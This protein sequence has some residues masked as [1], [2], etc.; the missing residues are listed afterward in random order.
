MTKLCMAPIIATLILLPCGTAAA[1]QTFLTFDS[2]P[3]DYIGGGI[4]QTWT[5]ADGTFTV[6]STYRGGI[7]A[8]FIAPGYTTWWNLDFG[9]PDA[10]ALTNKEYEGAQ[11]FA[12]HSPTKPGMDVSGSGRGCNRLTGR[13]LVS[14]LAVALDGTIERLAVDFEQHCEG[15]RP[16]LFG[17]LRFNSDVPAVPRVSVADAATLKGNVGTN[18]GTLTVSL[19][20]P[21]TDPVTVQYAT[22]DGTALAGTDYVA[23]TGTLTLD[24]G[25]TA[26]T[27]MIPT[28]GDRLARGDKSFGVRLSSL[29]GTPLGQELANVNI[30]DPNVPLTA[31]AMYGQPGDY[32]G[33]G[34]RLFTVAD[35]IFTP[36]NS[37]PVVSV[38]LNAGDSWSLDFAAPGNV[39]LTPGNYENAQRF[40]F[41]PADAPG[42][43]VS[44]EGRGCN[45]LTG[46][47]DVL[48]ASYSPSGA[49]QSFAAD[50]EQHCEGNVPALFGSLRV[51]SNLQQ[52]SVSNAVIDTINSTAVFTVTMTPPPDALVSVN[53]TT[54]DGTAVA[55]IDYRATSQAVTFGIGEGEQ[56]IT[57]PL[58]T[59]SPLEAKNFFGQLSSPSGA[60]IW[61]RRGSANLVPAE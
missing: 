48:D 30:L 61:I 29:D 10:Q 12:F 36:R 9:P 13:F 20:L 39:P 38:N 35:G 27:I 24:P 53:F 7:T 25:T 41:Q 26:Q 57:V 40:P 46:R 2:Q 22:E 32:I 21:S 11:R 54:V 42:L 23:S 16:A 4:Q 14:H 6:R 60:P 15:G 58:I 5:P 52:L 33:Q 17:S 51:N 31:L 43:D 19:C 8:S 3:G 18:D 47:F 1:A 45:R 50:F 55:G 59:P 44:G 28:M 49:V 34:L 37:S 56:T